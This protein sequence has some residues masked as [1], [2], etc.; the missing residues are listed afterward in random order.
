MVFRENTAVKTELSA[1]F[2][3]AT[4]AIILFQDIL[5]KQIIKAPQLALSDYTYAGQA[6]KAI[7][8]IFKLYSAAE[9]NLDRLIQKRVDHYQYIQN[10]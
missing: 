4:T 5:E 2:D 8:D 10:Q 1:R 6:S 3:T 9:P 7:G